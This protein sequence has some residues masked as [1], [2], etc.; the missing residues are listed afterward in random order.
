MTHSKYA[1]RVDTSGYSIHLGIF[2]Q[3]PQDQAGKE[4]PWLV[5]SLSLVVID[6]IKDIT[7]KS[8]LHGAAGHFS[9][10]VG[11]IVM[12]VNVHESTS[13]ATDSQHTW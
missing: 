13:I 4:I 6:V 8:A 1:G 3:S 2:C 5:L 7:N 12:R 10:E 11:P 9:Q